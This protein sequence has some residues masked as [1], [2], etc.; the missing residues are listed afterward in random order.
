MIV[1][2]AH[3]CVYKSGLLVYEHLYTYIVL[4]IQ[5]TL[6]QAKKDLAPV[7]GYATIGAPHAPLSEDPVTITDLNG[8]D[9]HK[10]NDPIEII[11]QFLTLA[12]KL[13]KCHLPDLLTQETMPSG[14]GV[15]QPV[16]LFVIR[17]CAL[18]FE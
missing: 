14:H 10:E 2:R 4:Y 16:S 7:P 8:A 13:L 12:F 1:A 5:E 6:L 18:S 17:Q 11:G 15:L 3:E 9:T